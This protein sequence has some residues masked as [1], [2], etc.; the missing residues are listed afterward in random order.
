MCLARDV[1]EYFSSEE[2]DRANFELPD[3]NFISLGRVREGFA[4]PLFSQEAPRS[5]LTSAVLEAVGSCDTD[6]KKEMVGNILVTGGNSLLYGLVSRL[7]ARIQEAVPSSVKAKVVTLPF[8][9]EKKY[10]QWIGG[11]ILGCLASFQSLWVGE[12]EYREQGPVVLD[13]K[14][15]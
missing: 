4:D 15:P 10:S 6:V 14:C 1:K 13:K 11:S 2:E 12:R 3:G 8:P 7:S 5:G 9:A